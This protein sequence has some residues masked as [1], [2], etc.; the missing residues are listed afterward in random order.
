MADA[1]SAPQTA[2]PLRKR[3]R[4]LRRILWGLAGLLCLAV[5]GLGWLCR[6]EGGQAWLK[7]QIN[8]VLQE[9]LASG[10]LNARLTSLSGPLPFGAR[11]GL[12]VG[13]ARGLWLTAPDNSFYLDWMALPGAVRIEHFR[14]NGARLGRLPQLPPAPPPP[15]AE[16]L[17]EEGLRLLLGDVARAVNA[18][19]GWLPA[20]RVEGVQLEKALVPASL[21]G[22]AVPEGEEKQAE[23]VVDL[24][25]QAL[26]AKADGAHVT[27]AAHLGSADGA[28]LIWP[29][30]RLTAADVD[31][32]ARLTS[33]SATAD[34][35]NEGNNEG[36]NLGAAV[37]LQATLAQPRLEAAD[38]P[39]DLLGDAPWL[40]L[41]VEAGV[42]AGA[43]G[44]ARQAH[45]A[46]NSLELNAGALTS[47]TRARWQQGEDAW[48]DG[49]ISLAHELALHRPTR[50]DEAAGPVTTLLARPSTLRLTADGSL[51]LPRMRLELNAAGLE[52]QGDVTAALADLARPA[53]DGLLRLRVADWQILSALAGQEMAGEAGLEVEFRALRT[54][55]EGQGEQSQQN[56]RLG[57]SVPR[58]SYGPTGLDGQ[59]APVR[60][61]GFSGEATLANCLVAPALSARLQLDRAAIEGMEL[62]T[63][64]RAGG[65][66]A[67]PLDVQLESSG[68]VASRLDV[69]WQPGLVSLRGLELVLDGLLPLLTAEETQGR[70][71]KKPH[72]LGL[73]LLGPAS[74][75]YGEGGYGVDGLRVAISPSGKL[76][77]QGRLAP[78]TLDMRVLLQ[79]LDLEPWRMLVPALPE[80]QAEIHARLAG[81]TSRP[82]GDWKIALHR[83]KLAGS[84]LAPL[85]VSLAGRIEHGQD[86]SALTARL[87]LPTAS[88]KALGGEEA[89]LNARLPLLFGADGVPAPAMDKPL[90]GEIY[91]QG[92]LGPLWSL[93][94]QADRRLNGRLALDVDLAGS[95]AAPVFKGRVRMDKGRFED[96]ALGVLLQDMK[97]ALDVDGRK[98]DAP[99]P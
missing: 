51:F 79:S 82:G 88:L 3:R 86:G 36:N 21:L 38:T 1:V 56:V 95:L 94:P 12:E 91:W 69:R 45:I 76:E 92:A 28:A 53:L 81:Q 31:L 44:P 27:A 97:F 13:D 19:P 54:L 85:D 5:V 71:G 35:A 22:A 49:P 89:R 26:W 70:N 64:L 43:E 32:S 23:A 11:F 66:L 14:V 48:L 73:R 61:E 58:F 7:E 55:A 41:E 8:A 24:D 83:L 84:P 72:S 57:W 65:P 15:P 67:G 40:V 62:G 63:S 75:R 93:V 29:G 74:V 98:V 52:S 17:T 77:A 25:V 46:L 42:S 9:A 90:R 47:Q 60:I 50:S 33:G 10:G 2:P 20:L 39:A 18:L 78:D 4:W 59:A 99:K 80:G 16:P 37:N 68:A 87:D 6:S 30:F 34:G 96:V